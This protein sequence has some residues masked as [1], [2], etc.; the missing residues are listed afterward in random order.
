MCRHKFL[1]SV[2]FFNAFKSYDAN[3]E[4]GLGEVETILE[5]LL[6]D[7]N[8]KSFR[9]I[10]SFCLSSPNGTIFEPFYWWFKKK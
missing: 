7:F 4:I 3:E 9:E 8:K 1:L 6:K 2:L 10:W 5:G